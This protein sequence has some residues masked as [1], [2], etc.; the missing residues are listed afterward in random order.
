[1]A[2]KKPV[3]VE[4]NTID[5]DGDKPVQSQTA[6]DKMSTVAA[7][8]EDRFAGTGDVKDEVALKLE[9][10][11]KLEKAMTDLTAENEMLKDKLAEYVEKSQQRQKADTAENEALKDR[12]AEYAQK[13]QQCPKA[14]AQ[15]TE[16]LKNEISKLNDEISKLREENDKYLM[17]ISELTFE[18]A[19]MHAEIDTLK[20]TQIADPGRIQQPNP[21]RNSQYGNVYRGALNGYDSWN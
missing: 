16:N 11:E 17:R 10:F 15:K 8:V 18:N 6:K 9:Q 20:K 12:L 1:M 7:V 14:D 19:K 5:M 21:S 2:K 4:F 3:D 13:L